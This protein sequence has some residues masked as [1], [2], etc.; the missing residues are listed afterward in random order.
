VPKGRVITQAPAANTSVDK[1]SRVTIV[2]SKGPEKV[3]VPNTV[4]E[5]KNQARSDL[6]AAGFKVRVM[7]Q[8]SATQP[9]GTVLS[10]TPPGGGKAVKGSTVTIFVATAPAGPG[11]TGPGSTTTT[12]SPP[13]TTP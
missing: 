9:P 4:T 1:G 11:G 3:D 13:P 12:P 5:T 2:V 8:E 6:R 7:T 10:Q